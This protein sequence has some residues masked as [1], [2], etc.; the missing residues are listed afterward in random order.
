LIL[1]WIVYHRIK[2]TRQQTQFDFYTETLESLAHWLDIRTFLNFEIMF[3]FICLS[4]QVVCQVCHRISSNW[5][6]NTWTWHR[7]R[8]SS[9]IGIERDAVYLNKKLKLGYKKYLQKQQMKSWKW[10][11]SKT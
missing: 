2:L 5:F 9:W 10:E 1:S 8:G 3:F 6:N 11:G 7:R 4:S